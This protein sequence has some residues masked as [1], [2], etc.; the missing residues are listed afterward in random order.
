[1]EYK[2]EETKNEFH[3]VKTTSFIQSEITERW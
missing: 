3:Y 1:M 2:E